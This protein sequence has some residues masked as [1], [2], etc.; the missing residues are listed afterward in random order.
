MRINKTINFNDDTLLD[1]HSLHKYGA[2]GKPE[3][4]IVNAGSQE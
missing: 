1:T 2:S 3:W 4:Q